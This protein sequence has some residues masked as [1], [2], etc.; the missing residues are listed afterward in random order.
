MK[1]DIS[2]RILVNSY[3]KAFRQ[4]K[5][6]VFKSKNLLRYFGAVYTLKIQLSVGI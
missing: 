2:D 4:K 1:N 6:L 3:K 5:N